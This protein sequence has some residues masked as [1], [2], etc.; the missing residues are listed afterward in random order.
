MRGCR[1]LTNFRRETVNFMKNH[2]QCIEN[3]D[4]IIVRKDKLIDKDSFFR[5][6]NKLSYDSGFGGHVI[7]LSLYIVFK[8]GS[9]MERSEYDGSE[10]WE[11]KSKLEKPNTEEL[12]YDK[13]D[14]MK[15]IKYDW[16]Y[17]EGGS[18]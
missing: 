15:E 13:E 7:D 6:I 12:L 1:D 9:W 18:Y 8:D 3:V 10:W 16:N 2:K 11:Y 4:Y 17:N 14:I 5:V